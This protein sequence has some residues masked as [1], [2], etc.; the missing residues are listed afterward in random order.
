M[1]KR[2]DVSLLFDFFVTAQRLKRTL[3]EA[4]AGSG[5]KPDEYA[6]YSLLFDH[7]PLTATEM[8][9]YLAMPLTTLLD[10]LKAMGAAGHLSRTRHPDDGR[11][12]QLRLSRSGVAAHARAHRHWEVMRRQIEDGL[13]IPIG[14]VRLALRAIDDSAA[15]ASAELTRPRTA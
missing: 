4:L 3:S 14:R 8:A 10:Y 11:A 6:V 12:R 7:G 2:A 15:T 1:P 5:M 9:E 13:S